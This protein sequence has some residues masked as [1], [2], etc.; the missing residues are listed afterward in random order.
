MQFQKL[1]IFFTFKEIYILR[2]I[3]YIHDI[4]NFNMVFSFILI[5][6]ACILWLTAI[7]CLTFNI[8][9]L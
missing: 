1:Q 5:Q 9:S 8:R 7:V 6:Q 2:V 4:T 3:D